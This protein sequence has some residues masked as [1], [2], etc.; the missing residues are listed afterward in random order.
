M[1]V[2]INR[3][4]DA[5]LTSHATY[6]VGEAVP[7]EPL[8][9]VATEAR[10]PP[11]DRR[12]HALAVGVGRA[13][14]L[15]VEP[16]PGLGL[17]EHERRLAEGVLPVPGRREHERAPGGGLRKLLPGEEPVCFP[18]GVADGVV[19]LQPATCQ[20]EPPGD[21]VSGDAA[22][23]VPRRA[24]VP[25]EQRVARRHG[26]V[27]PEEPLG[28]EDGSVADRLHVQDD[29]FMCDVP[30]PVSAEL[31][32][33][34]GGTVQPDSTSIGEAERVGDSNRAARLVASRSPC[35]GT[36]EEKSKEEEEEEET[37]VLMGR[38]HSLSVD[39]RKQQMEASKLNVEKKTGKNK[40]S[41]VLS[42][43][44]L[45][46][47]RSR[48]VALNDFGGC[49]Q[50]VKGGALMVKD[51]NLEQIHCFF[52]HSD[53]VAT[54]IVTCAGRN[55]LK[56]LR[57]KKRGKIHLNWLNL[58]LQFISETYGKDLIPEQRA[59][60]SERQTENPLRR[61]T[62]CVIAGAKIRKCFSGS[63]VHVAPIDAQPRDRTPNQPA[64]PS[65]SAGYQSKHEIA[66]C[67]MGKEDYGGV[68]FDR[69]KEAE[70][71][72][73]ALGRSVAGFVV[74]AVIV[75]SYYYCY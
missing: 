52:S 48:S 56:L 16:P 22:P 69:G 64:L 32:L 47:Q 50:M 43:S 46:K 54:L 75:V 62:T 71:H 6:A 5:G 51:V 27:A 74:V 60:N 65:D 63:I 36:E 8:V 14:A 23:V 55:N 41:V 42:S 24:A 21:F 10:T 70:T 37:K 73:R 30:D 11:G 28:S 19:A 39:Q 34:G 2:V 12:I 15:S 29:G 49:C 61:Q 20:V 18:A 44:L 40:V 31:H 9:A 13:S 45:A 57:K 33:P 26:V 58:P 53:K 3:R 17:S 59:R 7:D 72:S 1:E 68:P 38:R 67:P 4:E 66:W 35:S 25:Q